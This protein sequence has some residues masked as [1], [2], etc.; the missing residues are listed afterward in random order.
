MIAGLGASVGAVAAT[1]LT[2]PTA[3]DAAPDRDLVPD[4]GWSIGTLADSAAALPASH[5]GFFLFND[6]S[7]EYGELYVANLQFRDD[8]LSSEAVLG[9]G[10]PAGGA[11]PVPEPGSLAYLAS[12]VAGLSCMRILRQAREVGRAPKA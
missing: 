9:L 5:S 7:N 12:L 4:G 1:G 8:A 2:F 10:G 11:I 6:Q 3:A